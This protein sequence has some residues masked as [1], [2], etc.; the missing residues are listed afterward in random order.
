MVAT[1]VP[2][3]NLGQGNLSIDPTPALTPP[4]LPPL[5]T[6][7]AAEA[8]EA[9][10]LHSPRPQPVAGIPS[11]LLASAS[12]NKRQPVDFEDYSHIKK[13]KMELTPCNPGHPPRIPVDLL[14]I[15]VREALDSPFK[16]GNSAYDKVL[17]VFAAEP[18]SVEA[19]TPHEQAMYLVQ[20][21]TQSARFTRSNASLLK[22]MLN[23]NWLGRD[24]NYWKMFRNFLNNLITSQGSLVQLVMR[25]MVESLNLFPKSLKGLSGAMNP[26]S[27]MRR[28]FIHLKDVLRLVPSANRQLLTL[29]PSCFPAITDSK[30]AIVWFVSSLI[31]FISHAPYM[32]HEI[33]NIVMNCVVKLDVQVQVE[34][35][36]I[37]EDDDSAR[38]AA[39]Q[40]GPTAAPNRNNGWESDSSDGESDDDTNSVQQRRKLI[41]TSSQKVDGL[42][43]ILFDHH[44][45]AYDRASQEQQET[46]FTFI[47]SQWRSVV[48]PSFRSRHAQFLLFRFGQK[49]PQTID[50]V[51]TTLFNI[52]QETGRTAMERQA[53][54]SYLASFVAR[55]SRI[56]ED[57]IR[58]IFTMI[59]KELIG[60]KIAKESTC[61]G[62][63]L[64]KYPMVYG[65]FQVIIYIFCFRWRMLVEDTSIWEGTAAEVADLY[66]QRNF[67]WMDDVKATINLLAFSEFNPLKVCAPGIVSE[68]ARIANHLRLA[69]VYSKLEANKTILLSVTSSATVGTSGVV[70]H[71]SDAQLQLDGYFPFDP[72][73]LPASRQFVDDC[74]NAWPQIPGLHD[75]DS[76]DDE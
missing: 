20:L 42:M 34:L 4:L 7:L 72:Y 36:D 49:T 71:R 41:R 59:G 65:L 74:F 2:S 70:A 9:S 56:S 37:D 8:L 39:T 66:D 13:R 3:Q 61:Q 67:V 48:L 35:D 63:D 22:A 75:Q 62:P 24:E 33:L 68:F 54:A 43:R 17:N 51:I 76:D 12:P 27:L 57:K 69:F 32:R 18:G 50:K 25:H 31:S 73:E 14:E 47:L 64:A 46:Q 44:E 45:K 53:A 60:Y 21:A 40:Q 16:E 19:A 10:L 1:G 55:G 6:S 28:V 38:L 26:R 23:S 52:V 58:S 5:P 29:I 15:E 11:S 30:R